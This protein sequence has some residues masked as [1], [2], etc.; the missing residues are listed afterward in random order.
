MPAI[1]SKKIDEILQNKELSEKTKDTYK[2]AVIRVSK[3]VFGEATTLTKI[4]YKTK[5]FID[6][7]RLGSYPLSTKIVILS[8]LLCVSGSDQYRTELQKINIVR[9]Q[10]IA[11][12]QMSE[13]D[14]RE[15]LT[16]DQIVLKDNGFNE[17]KELTK[18]KILW[19][20]LTLLPCRR[21]QDYYNIKVVD[22]T[23]DNSQKK[24]VII[25]KNNE[26]LQFEFF[27]FKNARRK[28]D[29]VFDRNDM[30]GLPNGSEIL[31]FLDDVVKNKMNEFLFGFQNSD[32]FG[33]YI[34][35]VS[36]DL[37]LKPIT[38]NTYRHIYATNFLKDA[39]MKLS[40]MLKVSKFMGHS[41]FVQLLYYREDKENEIIL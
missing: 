36:K 9:N 7:V 39:D 21:L 17:Q 15:W 35:K 4:K 29:E 33:K 37:F 1:F 30:L 26:F 41:I 28:H 6:N 34:K 20:L 40:E 12:Q 18:E 22:E 5:H 23:F 24:N 2:N 25:G 38:I 27:E 14:E 19:K 8:A 31:H 32:S 10:E 3:E 13:K 16:I 11:N